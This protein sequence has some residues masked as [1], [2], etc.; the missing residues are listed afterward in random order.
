M[1][2]LFEGLS[3]MHD[4]NSE[5]FLLPSELRGEASPFRLSSLIN[6]SGFTEIALRVEFAFEIVDGNLLGL[7]SLQYQ[8]SEFDQPCSS[9][10]FLMWLSINCAGKDHVIAAMPSGSFLLS[11]SDLVAGFL[12]NVAR[13]LVRRDLPLSCQPLDPSHAQICL[14]CPHAA[15]T[16]ARRQASSFR[17]LVSSITVCA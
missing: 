17:A 11:A 6:L 1:G 14:C 13:Q 15:L 2:L 10:H 8:F 9:H 5:R 16:T 3:S 7:E 12:E 4:G